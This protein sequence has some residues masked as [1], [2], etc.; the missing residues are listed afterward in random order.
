MKGFRAGY[1]GTLSI[2]P[3]ADQAFSGVQMRTD[4]PLRSSQYNRE[5]SVLRQFSAVVL[6][7]AFLAAQTTTPERKVQGNV[8]TSERDPKVRIRLPDSAQYAGADRWVLY[9]IADCELHAF[10]DADEHKNVRKLYWIQFEGYLPTKPELKHTYD[11]PQH[12]NLGGLDF[13]VDTWVRTKDE[14]TR[15]GSDLE[16]IVNLV[17]R[18]GYHLPDA[19]MYVRLVN[20]FHDKQ[21]ELMIIYAE[22][23]EPTG[24]NAAELK[25]SW[26]NSPWP[27]VEK[28]LIKRAEKSVGIEQIR[29]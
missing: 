14:S 25:Q 12:A 15:Q 9:D 2:I 6:C 1:N 4:Q 29:Q 26:A 10:V 22:D 27:D 24:H 21:K 23:T 16:H 18:K 28:G 7:G 20:L 3:R 19:L 13:F 8:I 17:G 11:S 5:V